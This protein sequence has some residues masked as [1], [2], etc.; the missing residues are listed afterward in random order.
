MKKVL[1]FLLMMAIAVNLCACS[2]SSKAIKATVVT[3]SGETKQM[4]LE[5]IKDIAES[6]SILFEKE[7]VGADITVT[8]TITKIGG[9]FLLQSWFDC[10]AYVELD[11]GDTISCWFHP[12]REEYAA[13]LNVGDTITVSGKIGMASV[14]GFDVYI[15]KDAISPY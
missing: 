5:E 7:Y 2:G 1:A 3:N 6:N 8:S 9:A 11:A 14:S 10:E 15:L 4:T 13:T 12:V